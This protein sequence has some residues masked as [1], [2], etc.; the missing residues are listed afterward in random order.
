MGGYSFGQSFWKPTVIA[1]EQRRF[2][3]EPAG[4]VQQGAKPVRGDSGD[5]S[6]NAI[7]LLTLRQNWLKTYAAYPTTACPE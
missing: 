6:V 7:D 1:M 2:T 5:G 4:E 3:D